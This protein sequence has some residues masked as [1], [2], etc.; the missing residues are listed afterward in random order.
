MPILIEPEF[1]PVQSQAAPRAAS[2][3]PDL[4]PFA[5]PR[6]LRLSLCLVAAS[7]GYL[8]VSALLDPRRLAEVGEFGAAWPLGLLMIPLGYVGW[9]AVRAVVLRRELRGA[10]A[11]LARGEAPDAEARLRSIVLRARVHQPHLALAAVCGLAESALARGEPAE[12]LALLRRWPL[13]CAGHCLQA[14]AL[15]LL[16][17]ADDAQALL[18]TLPADEP[19]ALAPR[20]LTLLCQAEFAAAEAILTSEVTEDG[21]PLALPLLRAFAAHKNDDLLRAEVQAADLR[22]RVP[23]ALAHRY[24]PWPELHAFTAA[25]AAS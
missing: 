2:P 20:A 9:L 4:V 7:M 6:W 23:S 3:A 14:E 1:S 17:Q 15:V 25:L 24:R 11:L 18:A 16:R 22:G 8:V 5:P 21:A 13:D 10:F 19:R 12:A